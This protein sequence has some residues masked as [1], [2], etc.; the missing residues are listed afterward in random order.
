MYLL[1]V[2]NPSQPMSLL[3][4]ISQNLR[5][6]EFKSHFTMKSTGHPISLPLRVES[7]C[8]SHPLGSA[9]KAISWN[10]YLPQWFSQSNCN[11]VF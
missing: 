8:W 3:T 11:Q 7:V 10:G 9:N 2:A 1:P 6:P 4:P 5:G